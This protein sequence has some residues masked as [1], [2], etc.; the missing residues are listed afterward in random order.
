MLTNENHLFF[1]DQSILYH[2]AA[3]KIKNRLFWIHPDGIRIEF[4][5]SDVKWATNE[6]SN[7]SSEQCLFV[8]YGPNG[9]LYSDEACDKK[10]LYICEKGGYNFLFSNDSMMISAL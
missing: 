8:S 7:C 9:L 6:P 5:K 10:A 4:E 2:I 1:L 3:R